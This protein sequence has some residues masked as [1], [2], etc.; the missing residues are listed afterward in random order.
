MNSSNLDKERALRLF[1]YLKEFSMLE[2]P[3]VR[4]VE[5]YD[6]VLWFSEVPEEKECTTPLQDGDFHDVWIEI[7]K[8][9]KPPVS[10]PSEKIVTWLESEDELNNENKEPKLVEQIPNPNYVE[11]D[12]DESP[13]PR[14]INLNDHPEITNEFQKYMENEWMPWKEEVFRFKKVQSIYTDLFSIY[15]K[16]KNLGEQFELIVGVGLLN[17]KS[18]NGQIVHCHLLNVPA[19]FGFDADTGVITVV[20]TAQGI[21]PDLEQDMLELEDRLDSSSLQPV[22][23]LIHLL[24][25]NFW[26]KTT[27][28]T[29]L[30]SYV[31][32][33]SAEGVYYEEEIENK[34]N[35]ANEPIVLYSPALILRKR[36]EKGFQQACTK[37]IDNIESDPSSIPQGVTRIFKTMDDLQPNGI[38]GMDTG[39]EAEDNIIY[40][41]KEA[42]EEQE[43]I[44]SRL[45]SRNGVIVQGPPGTGKSHTIANLTSHLLATGKRVLIT[46]ETD[47]ALKVLKAKLPKE[48]QGLC[49]SLLGADSQSFKDLEHVIHMISNER[50]DWDP[51]VTQKEIEN[52]LKSSMI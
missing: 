31:Q 52:I 42:N 3:L 18:P 28:D 12:E 4:N 29:I 13:E 51:D 45:S 30:R 6:D 37:I 1:T 16:H 49:V 39:V 47:R 19:T 11:D 41:P 8:P 20:P 27:Q 36:V 35:F 5:N 34:H 10:S 50:D 33:L 7:E 21:N 17:W 43:K 2:T 26:D 14:Y 38:E 24:Q 25:E 23:E 9:I 44:I 48:L 40:F 32:S 46:S 22:I 15:Q